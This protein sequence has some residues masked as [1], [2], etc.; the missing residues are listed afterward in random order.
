MCTQIELNKTSANGK[1]HTNDLGHHMT[2]CAPLSSSHSA[3]GGC[4][5]W[6]VEKG[7]SET[8]ESASGRATHTHIHMCTTTTRTLAQSDRQTAKPSDSDVKR[9]P[10]IIK[11]YF[12]APATVATRLVGLLI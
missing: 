3:V 10:P 8:K 5:G 2:C 11:L 12:Y 9:P 1:S 6:A 7:E 4:S